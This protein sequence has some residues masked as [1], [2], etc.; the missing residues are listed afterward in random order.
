LVLVTFDA[1]K[2][3]ASQDLAEGQATPKSSLMLVPGL[4]LAWTDQVWPLKDSTRVWIGNPWVDDAE[5]P[6]AVHEAVVRHHT[7]LS[8]LTV[9]PGLGLT[10]TDQV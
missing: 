8:A 10:W 1:V 5:A 4:G 2:P 7:P 3:M 6:T 9:A